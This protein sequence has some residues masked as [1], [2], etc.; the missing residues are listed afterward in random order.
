MRVAIDVMGGDKGP[1]TVVT[2]AIEGARVNRCGIVLVGDEATIQWSLKAHD[3]EGLDVSVVHAADEIT[4]DDHPAQAVR[5]KPNASMNVAMRLVKD[6]GAD[7]MLSTGNSGAMMA[8]GLM[9]LGRIPGID[10]PAITSGVPNGKN[11][12][13]MLVDLGA[14]TD[15][16]PVNMVQFAMMGQVYAKTVAGID[17]PTIGLLANGEEDSK[18]NQ[19]TLKVHPMLRATEGL[20]F[21]G[22]VEGRDILTGDVDVVVMDGFTGNIVLKAIEGTASMLMQILRR[23]LT[24]T[25]PRKLAALALKPAF[26]SLAKRLDPSEV[27]GAPLLGVNGVVII[28][29][30]SSNEL[31]ITNAVGVAV[32]AFEHD[33]TG[34]IQKRVSSTLEASREETGAS[35]QER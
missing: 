3:I 13:T 24:A 35:P 29:H 20:N 30:G 14:V 21:I 26:K 9:V 31:A 4:M 27:G 1:E 10:R 34:E 8:S 18:G 6:G 28:T 17:N 33:L 2:G 15:P 11:G 23:E 19:L 25:L 7:A 22:N 5:R 32:R 16:K 12:Y